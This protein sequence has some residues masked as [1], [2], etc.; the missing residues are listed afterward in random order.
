MYQLQDL[1]VREY[2]ALDRA[3]E[4]KFEYIDGALRLLTG[5]TGNHSLIAMNLG[6]VLRRLLKGQT[7]RVFNSDM[8]VKLSKRRYVYPDLTVTCDW[9]QQLSDDTV[10]SPLLI[11]EVLSPSTEAYVRKEKLSLYKEVESIQEILLVDSSVQSIEVYRRSEDE[12]GLWSHHAF[13]VAGELELASLEARFPIA[14]VYEQ[15]TVPEELE[16]HIP[17]EER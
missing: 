15:T 9:R 1:T 5:G 3:S 11:V 17:T 14:A 8:R 10:R 7:C 13:S 6:E 12:P 16:A 2:L 4:R